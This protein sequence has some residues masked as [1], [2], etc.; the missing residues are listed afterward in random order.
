MNT[1]N[2]FFAYVQER[3]PAPSDRQRLEEIATGSGVP[4]HTLLKI[5]KGETVDPRVSTVESLA[6]YFKAQEA[7]KKA[8]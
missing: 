2:R 8:A 6:D 3:L 4:Y 7:K 5:A 1:E